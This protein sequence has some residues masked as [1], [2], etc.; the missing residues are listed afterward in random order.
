MIAV[1]VFPGQVKEGTLRMNGKEMFNYFRDACNAMQ[2]VL[3]DCLGLVLE[4]AIQKFQNN[5]GYTN[6]SILGSL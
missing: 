6:V 3:Q 2:V 1:V 4:G 5:N